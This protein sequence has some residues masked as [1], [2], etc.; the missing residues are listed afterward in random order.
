MN[1]QEWCQIKERIDCIFQDNPNSNISLENWI[2]K[3]KK[4]TITFKV[5]EENE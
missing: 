2:C 5:K 4:K 3:F 1:K